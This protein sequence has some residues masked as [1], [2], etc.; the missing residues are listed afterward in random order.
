M[1]KVSAGVTNSTADGKTKENLDHVVKAISG[2]VAVDFE[3][4]S[5]GTVKL[6]LP[7]SDPN[8][9]GQLWADSGA[10]KVSTG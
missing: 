5:G 4:K 8:S 9:A 7:T 3:L 10:V 2:D 1:A 6:N